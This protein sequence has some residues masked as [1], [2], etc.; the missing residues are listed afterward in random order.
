MDEQRLR[1]LAHELRADLAAVVHGGEQ[2]RRVHDDIDAALALPEGEGLRALTKAL[3]QRRET[4]EWVASRESQTETDRM[5]PGLL[6]QVTA[7]GLGLHV[8]CPNCDYDRY[9]ESP[10]E[11]PGRCPNDGSR[12]VPAQG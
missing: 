7:V 2:R 4:R 10:N 9:L 12:L 1:E 6:G 3:S 11:D 5:V 8:V